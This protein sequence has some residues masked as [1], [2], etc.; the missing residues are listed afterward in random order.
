MQWRHYYPT[1]AGKNALGRGAVASRDLQPVGSF[2]LVS[3]RS[4][5][6]FQLKHT[7]RVGAR[8]ATMRSQRLGAVA[9]RPVSRLCRLVMT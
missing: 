9:A 2:A 1:G 6:H 4:Q 8:R 5:S 3:V 7:G